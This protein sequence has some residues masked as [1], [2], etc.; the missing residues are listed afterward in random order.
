[1]DFQ[2]QKRRNL[3]RRQRVRVS[4]FTFTSAPRHGKNR[5]NVAIT[6]RVEDIL[7]LV[8]SVKQRELVLPQNESTNHAPF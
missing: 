2:R 8:V 7:T 4:G 6:Q 5:L 3:L 1:L